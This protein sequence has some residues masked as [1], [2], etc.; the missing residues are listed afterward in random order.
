MQVSSVRS[1]YWAG[2][3]VKPKKFSGYLETSEHPEVGDDDDDDSPDQIRTE[4]NS[5][6][7]KANI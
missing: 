4:K 3:T 1:D 6:G 5:V 2:K 7:E